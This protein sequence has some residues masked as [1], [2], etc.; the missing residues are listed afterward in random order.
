[1]NQRQKTIKVKKTKIE[2]QYLKTLEERINANN[3][4]SSLKIGTK[5]CFKYVK[6]FRFAFIIALTSAFMATFVNVIVLLGINYITQSLDSLF[7]TRNEVVNVFGNSILIDDT[8]KVLIMGGVLLGLYFFLGLFVF[9]MNFILTKIAN[10]IGYYLRMDLFNKIQ[11]LKLSY[12]DTHESGNTMSIL[13]NDVFYVVIFISQ[14]F[15][16]FVQ[17]VALILGMTI[18]MFLIS[19]YL[20]LIEIGIV[21]IL[22]S[23]TKILSKMSEKRFIQQ[24][25]K[26]G[27]LNG[28]IEEIISAQNVVNLFRREELTE[29]E[30][31]KYNKALCAESQK[32]QTISGLFIPSMNFLNNFSTVIIAIVATIFVIQ[33]VSFGSTLFGNFEQYAPMSNQRIIVAVAVINTFI[34]ALRSFTQPINNIVAMISQI[35]QA[36][37]GARRTSE[38]FLED[39]EALRNEKVEIK[40]K[41]VGKVN[42]NNLSFGYVPNKTILKNINLEV[43]PQNTIAIVGPTGS[44][45][46]TLINLL[47]K[48]YD[49]SDGD[50]VFDDTYHI[51]DIKKESIRKEVSIVLQDTYLFSGTIKEN[52]RFAKKDAT[53][54]EIF[55]V[56]SIANCDSFI[57]Q[58]ENGY[59]TV[60][61]ENAIELSQ[62]QKQLIAI[63]RA[64][65]SDSSILILD[66]ATS[67]IDT[68]TERVVQ[69][70]MN[71]LIAQK[72]AFIIAHRLSTIRNAD[73]IIVIK[74]GEIIEYGNHDELMDLKGFY[75]QLNQSKSGIVDEVET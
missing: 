12:F 68:R 17:A 15:G 72:T 69:D 57:N 18:V 44:G 4:L 38:V 11:L 67:S 2:I 1:M 21:I 34:V 23:Y 27:E 41:L 39:N 46:T 5:I 9:I 65:L 14:N 49:I 74:F 22:T 6:H 48:F 70:A 19:P 53:D 50:I 63:A 42:I 33:N 3:K 71:K 60:L 61:S 58:L 73:K 35:Q 40:Q 32:A 30:F 8:Y 7:T 37:A 36:F 75:Y 56:G 45:K 29:K 59:D 43:Q 54:E 52:I 31:E 51:K 16:N 55:K 26:L 10:Q 24:Q 62:G 20:A 25:K 47:T 66:E 28:Y 13:S 64:M